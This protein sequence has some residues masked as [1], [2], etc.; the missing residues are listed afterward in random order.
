MVYREITGF[1][2]ESDDRT[3]DWA[4]YSEA[5]VILAV[6][7]ENPDTSFKG[8]VLLDEGTINVVW[9]SEGVCNEHPEYSITTRMAEVS[10]LLEA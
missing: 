1:K 7:A 10:H 9:T 4:G 2:L 8:Q 6:D 3:D 5:C